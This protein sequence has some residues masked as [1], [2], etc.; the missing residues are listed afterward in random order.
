MTVQEIIKQQNQQK[1]LAKLE[2]TRPELYKKYTEMQQKI[3]ENE[4]AAAAD[5]EK[6]AEEMA[7]RELMQG[8]MNKLTNAFA[9]IWTDIADALLAIANT[10]M[11]PIIIKLQ[12]Y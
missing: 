10:I 1:L 5:L 9:A 4:K 11:P 7:K 2:Q 6:Q 3:K 8:E 12:D